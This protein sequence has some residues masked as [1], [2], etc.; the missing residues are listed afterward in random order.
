[1]TAFR[2]IG[3]RLQLAA[4]GLLIGSFFLPPLRLKLPI[5]NIVAVLD[6]TGSMNT[7]DEMSIGSAASRIALEKA[8]LADMLSALPCGSR[9]GLAIFVERRPFLLFEPIESC[10]NY[11]LLLSEI[12]AIDWKMGWD[13]ESHVAL[14]LHAAMPMAGALNA[15]LI[16]MT[17]GQEEPPLSWTGAPD[18]A[19]V[20]GTTHGL[21]A[22][23]GGYEFSPIPRFDKLG[24]EIG[25]WHKGEVPSETDGTFHGHEYQS[26][27]DEPHLRDL[28]RQSNLTYI[29]LTSAADLM[30]AF[31]R[32]VPR[33]LHSSKLDVQFI[34]ASLALALLC[35]AMIGRSSF[36]KKRSKKLL[37]VRPA[38]GST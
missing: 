7:R 34:P 38:F 16:F 12:A 35:W 3:F 28:A 22:G 1:M 30:P 17:D 9:L 5:Y 21:L 37:P 23:L 26:A 27:V 13:S 6:I 18:F 31:T 29:H 20:R 15:D 11:S 10:G 8:A 24:R 33:R 14:A 4:L 32:A 25:V 36:L 2:Q 19:S